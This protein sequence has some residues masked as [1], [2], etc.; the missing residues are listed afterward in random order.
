MKNGQK[1]KLLPAVFRNATSIHR[2]GTL[3]RTLS[4]SF[5]NGGQEDFLPKSCKTELLL[6]KKNLIRLGRARLGVDLLDQ[7]HGSAGE[8]GV[9]GHNINGR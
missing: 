1:P 7:F 8:G 2:G 5:R 9:K 3:S 4:P 6:R